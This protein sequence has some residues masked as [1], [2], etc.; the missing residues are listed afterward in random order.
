MSRAH[1]SFIPAEQ[2]NAVADW[3]FGAVDQAAIRFAAKLKAQAEAQFAVS[4][5]LMVDA[6]R[7]VL[8]RG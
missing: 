8:A 5:A 1:S 4:E 6:V 2:V 3:N 7:K